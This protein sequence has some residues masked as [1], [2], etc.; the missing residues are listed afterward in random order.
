MLEELGLALVRI[1]PIVQLDPIE[2]QRIWSRAAM[3]L[4]VAF[5]ETEADE[6]V[7]FIEFANVASSSVRN[8]AGTPLGVQVTINTDPT[9]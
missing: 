7:P 9:P 6:A 1:E 3:D 5:A 4:R 2:Y 8:P